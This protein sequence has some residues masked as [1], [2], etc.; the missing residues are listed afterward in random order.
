MA[1]HIYKTNNNEN[2]Q[3]LIRQEYNQSEIEAKDG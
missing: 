3:I 2:P 1:T